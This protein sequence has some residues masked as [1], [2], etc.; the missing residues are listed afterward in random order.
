[1]KTLHLH[2]E[3]YLDALTHNATH[4]E[5]HSPVDVIDLYPRV[6]AVAVAVAVVTI[7]AH[8]HLAVSLT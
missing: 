6:V 7:L 1:L 2:L 5:S 3:I 8:A 4:V